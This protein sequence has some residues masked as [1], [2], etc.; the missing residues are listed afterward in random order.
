MEILIVAGAAVFIT[1]IAFLIYDKRTKAKMEIDY[2]SDRAEPKLLVAETLIDYNVYNLKKS[3]YV[4]YGLIGAVGFFIIGYIFYKSLVVAIVFSLL[5][6]FFPK[7]QKKRLLQN[8]KQELS[9]QFQQALFSVSSS[10]VAG[11]SIENAFLEVSKDLELLYPDP[12]TY[13]IKEFELINRRVANR[14]PIESAIIDFSERAGVDDITNFTDVFVTCKRTGGDLV[15]VIR[16]TSNM[17][18]EKIEIQQEISVMVAQKKFESRIL[19]IMP[20]LMIALLGYTA[21]EYMEPLYDLRGIVGPIVMT[22]CL[23]IIV[24]SFWISQRIMN[25]KV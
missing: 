8:R 11:R 5:G 9:N 14:E 6:L 4:F 20:V 23:G 2:E 7:L 10:L 12:N 21:G 18:S 24:F 3:E 17:I 15:E 13:I 1:I 19:S 22:I 16:R 25:I